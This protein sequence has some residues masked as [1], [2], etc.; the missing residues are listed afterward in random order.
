MVLTEIKDSNH[1]VFIRD[2]MGFDGIGV[3]RAIPFE[4]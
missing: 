3:S 4:C 1:E 2:M